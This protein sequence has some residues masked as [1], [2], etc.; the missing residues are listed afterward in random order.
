MAAGR[1]LRFRFRGYNFWTAWARHF[2]VGTGLEIHEGNMAK[3]PKLTK[4]KIYFKMAAGRHLGF[5]F[6]GHDFQTAWARHFKFGRGLEI[7]D[8]NMAE[9]PKLIKIKIQDG[10]GRYLG[11][12]FRVHNFW[13]A[14]ARHFKYG[15]ELEIHDGNMTELPKLTKIKIQ[16][17]RRP[18]SCISV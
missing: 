6:R 1:H 4:V 18:Q 9:L 8:G 5:R 2:E 12:Q 3:L 11:F 17:G 7:H 14:S 13:P 16:D 15:T 10:R